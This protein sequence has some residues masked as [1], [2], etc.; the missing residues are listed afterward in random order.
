MLFRSASHHSEK[1]MADRAEL[2]ELLLIEDGID[3]I[4]VHSKLPPRPTVTWHTL[5]NKQARALVDSLR[6]ENAL[7]EDAKK[8]AQSIASIVLKKRGKEI[9]WIGCYSDGAYQYKAAQ[10]RLKRNLLPQILE[11]LGRTDLPK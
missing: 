8:R 1:A 6:T 3:E 11:E 5:T 10:F 9:A 2:E 7:P 4:V